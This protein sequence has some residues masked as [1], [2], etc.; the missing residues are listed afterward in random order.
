[1]C[2]C[3]NVQEDLSRFAWYKEWMSRRE[4]EDKVQHYGEVRLFTEVQ[5]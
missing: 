3:V 1:M 4:A 2:V 5:F